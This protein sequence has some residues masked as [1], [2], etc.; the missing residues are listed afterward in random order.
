MR[1]NV[2]IVDDDRSMCDML[3]AALTRREYCVAA[4]TSAEE[5]LDAIRRQPLDVVVTDLSMRGMQGLELCERIVASHPGVPV[6]VITAFGSLD[7][8]IAAIRAGA[9]DFLAKPFAVEALELSLDRAVHV[10]ALREEVKRLRSS[11]DQ[12]ES[13]QEL[14]GQSPAMQKLHD[15]LA[16]IA[17]SEASVLLTGETG[18]GKE[19]VARALHRRSRRGEHQFVAV[20]CAAMPEAL[21]ESELFGHT[22]G[23]FTDAKTS[24][25][26]LFVEAHGGTLFLDELGN[27]PLGLQPKLLRVLQE[28]CVRPVGGDAEVPVDV[29]IIASTNRDLETAVAEGQFREDLFFR[30]NVIY[31]ELPPLRARGNDVLLLAQ[32]FVRQFAT[33]ANKQVVG[34]SSG[35]AQKLL[36]YGWPGNVRELQNC[37]ERAVA[38]A[39][40]EEITV[41]DLPE[42]IANY[43]R[44]HVLVVSDDPNELPPLEEVER[45]YILRAL[46]AVGGNKTMAAKILGLDRKT[47]YRKL[48]HYG[49]V[50]D[51]P[52]THTHPD[53]SDKRGS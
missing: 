25:K 43:N 32:C 44:S 53:A 45:R 51:C 33:R 3:V 24:R 29:R 5:A 52:G 39:N 13:F 16:R 46:E 4:A 36:A 37:I 20:N 12:T 10:C 35:A 17:D 8:A 19:L 41:D 7:T 6:I 26:G 38:L 21:L 9:Y 14:V 1:G 40:Y 2:L 27:M 34:L 28:R 47:L 11:L 23:A 31:V 48:E 18:T 49:P 42:R 30:I 15:V 50:R 22:K